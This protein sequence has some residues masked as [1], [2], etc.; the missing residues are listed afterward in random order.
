MQQHV[1]PGAPTRPRISS[2]LI[3]GRLTRPRFAAKY[4]VWTSNYFKLLTS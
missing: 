3:S 4:S 1:Q 2:L